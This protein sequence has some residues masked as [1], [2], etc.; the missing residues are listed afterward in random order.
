MLHAKARCG[1]GRQCPF[2]RFAGV[3]I[4]EHFLPKSCFSTPGGG[5]VRKHA[6]L[7]AINGSL[8]GIN[9]EN[10]RAQHA[11]A[12]PDVKTSNPFFHA[13]K[14]IANS[15]SEKRNKEPVMPLRYKVITGS[16][17]FFL[18][19]KDPSKNFTRRIIFRFRQ[20]RQSYSLW[21]RW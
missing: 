21:H 3:A 2:P 12:N 19:I 15:T 8:T 13:T 20:Y 5:S 4:H 6:A 9:V 17:F 14:P 7:M 11:Q 1:Y 10:Q 16:L 18:H